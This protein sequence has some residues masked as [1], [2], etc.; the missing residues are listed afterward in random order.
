[1]HKSRYNNKYKCNKR[2][3]QHPLYLNRLVMFILIYW[4]KYVKKGI[5]S[6]INDQGK[7]ILS[8]RLTFTD[9]SSTNQLFSK[10]PVCSISI[11]EE[12]TF[13]LQ[14]RGQ[15]VFRL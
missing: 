15:L 9:S 10:I 13:E 11:S 7:V 6:P 8:Y 1:M 12:Q 3:L 2:H 14:S 5:T 4:I